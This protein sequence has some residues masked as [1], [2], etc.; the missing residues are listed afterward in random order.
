MLL[1]AIPEG[2]CFF[3]GLERLSLR[4]LTAGPGW[5]ASYL[6]HSSPTIDDAASCGI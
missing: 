1:G 5:K 6:S 4:N 2:I 3:V